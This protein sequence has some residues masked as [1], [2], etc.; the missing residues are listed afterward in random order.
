MRILVVQTAFLG[1]IVLTTPLLRELRR[2]HPG[3]S[4]SVVTTEIGARLLT[5][6]LDADH[7]FVLDKRWNRSGTDSCRELLRRLRREP[8]DAAVAAHRSLRTGIIVRLCGAPLRVGFAGAP[9]AWAYNRRVAWDADKHAVRRYLDLT[10]PLGGLPA[11]ADPRPA[12]AVSPAADRRVGEMLRRQHIVPGRDIVCIAPGSAWATKRWVPEGFAALLDASRRLGLT[13][14]LIGSAG[15]RELCRAV[16]ALAQ[17]PAP[18]LAGETGVRELIALL[19]RARAL[20]GNDSGPAH[21][22]SA[23]GTPVVTIFGPTAPANGYAAFGSG[24]RFVE[25]PSLACR[26]CGRH[27]ARL[28]PLGH[29]RC[30]REIRPSA[31]IDRLSEL[32]SASQPAA[33]V[34]PG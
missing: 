14:V 24:T 29:F 6:G 10:A 22:A 34:A 16:N 26:P 30:M 7:L 11:E 20:V 23:V 13:P 12:L 2:V 31:V 18:V 5:E 28:C 8:F 21:V 15:E 3:A 32:L 19:A 17:E 27:G 33:V 25:H 4:L 1:D 9:G